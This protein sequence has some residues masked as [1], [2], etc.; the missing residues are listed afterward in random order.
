MH[1]VSVAMEVTA[2]I[3]I[4]GINNP[5]LQFNSRYY[6]T[7]EDTDVSIQNLSLMFGSEVAEGLRP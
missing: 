5:D 2:A 1:V 3:S 7:H 4:E 6:M